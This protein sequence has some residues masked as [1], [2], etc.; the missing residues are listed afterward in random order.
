MSL[1]VVRSMRR[2]R[3]NS[4]LAVHFVVFSSAPDS[5]MLCSEALSKS[6]A[7][8]RGFNDVG[9]VLD[10]DGKGEESSSQ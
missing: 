4:G 3:R 6:T 8:L 9:G 10:V 7:R 1:A 2:R 5:T